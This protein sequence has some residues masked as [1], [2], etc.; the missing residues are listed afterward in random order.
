MEQNEKDKW[1]DFLKT[2]P[3]K[4]SIL[5]EKIPIEV[6]MAYFDFSGKIKSDFDP[7]DLLKDIDLL[8]NVDYSLNDKKVLLSRLASLPE[9]EAY[10]AIEKYASIS[11]P[12]LFQWAKLAQLESRMLLESHFLEESQ[13]LIATGL[14]GKGDLL[15]YYFVGFPLQFNTFNEYQ[16]KLITS[17]FE[18]SL[19]SNQGELEELHFY[20]NWFTLMIL[21]PFKVDVR[22]ILKKLINECNV[23][24]SF[25]RDNFIITNVKVLENKEIESFLHIMDNPKNNQNNEE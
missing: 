22:N 3:D 15:R 13:V 12:E 4:Y 2:L 23:Y 20:D 18:S 11:D 19:N 6:Q 14:G 7:T 9:V 17:E 10:R 16:K 24:G 21:L 8:F 1:I 25:L 5:Q